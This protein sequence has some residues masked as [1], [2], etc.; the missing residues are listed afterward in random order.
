MSFQENLKKFRIRAGYT[1][2]KDFAKVLG[3]SYPTYMGYENR[4]REPK[5]ELLTKIAKTLHVSIDDLLGYHFERPDELT[6]YINL[7]K[8]VGFSIKIVKDNISIFLHNVFVGNLKKESF[9]KTVRK[10][11]HDERFIRMKNDAL[12]FSLQGNLHNAWRQSWQKG[13][14][15]TKTI[16]TKEQQEKIRPLLKEY[17]EEIKKYP[18]SE[19][20]IEYFGAPGYIYEER[21]KKNP[22]SE[23]YKAY[24]GSES[25]SKTK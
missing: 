18:N 9:I 11:L 14:I 6:Q 23:E 15:S 4:G 3:I 16:L 12:C 5:F 13:I 2:A 1:Q 19:E 25:D 7:C 8:T 24:F 21:L 17:V 22:D 10:T 20:Y